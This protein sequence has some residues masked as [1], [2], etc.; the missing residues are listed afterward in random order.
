MRRLKFADSEVEV[1]VTS[2]IM[3]ILTRTNPYSS[4]GED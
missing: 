1:K 4:G 2:V 3:N